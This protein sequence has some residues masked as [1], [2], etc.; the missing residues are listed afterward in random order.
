[1]GIAID[2]VG[3][4]YVAEFA[5]KRIGTYS[6]EG[7]LLAQWGSDGQEAWSVTG[8]GYLA[9]DSSDHLFV[10]EWTTHNVSQSGV[11]EFTTGGDFVTM[12]GTHGDAPPYSPGTFSSPSGIAVGTDGRLYVTD[13]G[14]PR[15]QVF[16]SD[17]T[18]LSQ[19]PSQGNTIALDNMGHAFEVEEGGFVRKYDLSGAELA[20]WGG[21]GSGPGQ[22]NMPQ[23]VAVDVAGNV[24][25]TDTYNH[26]VQVFTNDGTFLTQWGSYGSAPGEFY[27]PMG[28]AMGPDGNVYVAD[29]WNGRIQVFG[30]AVTPALPITWGRI[31]SLYR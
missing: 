16:A 29:T 26:R 18:Y 8:P 31:K 19:W 5:S 27:R 25:V 17:H 7:A 21:Y 10:A 15:T 14:I 12:F 6:S 28:I 24:Y 22:F 20:H 23:G 3:K 4:V 13:T 1:M 11:Q 30:S 2:E 9:V